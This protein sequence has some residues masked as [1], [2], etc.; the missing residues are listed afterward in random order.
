MYSTIIVENSTFEITLYLL[1][2]Y[3]R[4]YTN[5]HLIRNMSSDAGN[6]PILQMV[7]AS[8]TM[9]PRFLRIEQMDQLALEAQRV[10]QLC[11]IPES[12][13]SDYEK[14]VNG[15]M[16][17]CLGMIDH[18][19]EQM[20]A[21]SPTSNEGNNSPMAL[22]QSF[23][24]NLATPI[25]VQNLLIMSDPCVRTKRIRCHAIWQLEKLTKSIR[26][27]W[28]TK[29]PNGKKFTLELIKICGT[30]L[31]PTKDIMAHH[32]R[33]DAPE[34]CVCYK[35][36]WSLMVHSLINNRASM[37]DTFQVLQQFNWRAVFEL[38]KKPLVSRIKPGDPSQSTTYF[39]V[40]LFDE[41]HSVA[42]GAWKEQSIPKE[43][44]KAFSQELGS[45]NVFFTRNLK[46]I[47]SG[48][49]WSV[50]ANSIQTPEERL[51]H[52]MEDMNIGNGETIPSSTRVE[53]AL[54]FVKMI[55]AY[56][57]CFVSPASSCRNYQELK[58]LDALVFNVAK[59]LK[60]VNESC[61][62]SDYLALEQ[63]GREEYANTGRRNFEVCLHLLEMW[64][65]IKK[66]SEEER[67][68]RFI[69]MYGDGD[70]DEDRRQRKKAMKERAS[71][72][73]DVIFRVPG[74]DNSQ[75]DLCANCFTLESDLERKLLNCSAC[76]QVK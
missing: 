74:N 67:A 15:V 55:I 29:L 37:K 14:E 61:L 21:A 16:C 43:E 40:T 34:S 69:E 35:T 54:P 71:A 17:N 50:I 49:I 32:Q 41:L 2:I 72:M 65:F 46:R 63:T 48:E 28:K 33:C 70:S 4:K 75:Y 45:C 47:L 51:V 30:I 8:P 12:Q 39:D 5:F 23:R 25:N 58:L 22:L 27:V 57:S 36:A 18:E 42:A 64:E 52:L 60:N 24:S 13:I 66:E 19:L 76:R 56:F 31:D 62:L 59:E 9:V 20:A 6:F 73:K 44:I 68:V 3:R 38:R 26:S 10:F 7:S 11:I 1:Q 53:D